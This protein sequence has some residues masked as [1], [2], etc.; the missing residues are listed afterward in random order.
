MAKL[1]VFNVFIPR[2]DASQ[3]TR[4]AQPKF[5]SW[6]VETA[7]RF[8]SVTLVANDVARLW[9]NEQQELQGEDCQ[10]FRVSV[11]PSRR[12]E[13]VGHVARTA[14]SFGQQSLLLE[15]AGEAEIIWATQ[16]DPV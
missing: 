2:T 16:S 5:E 3:A 11:P 6:Y 10:W 1:V 14:A 15:E 13:F 9:M 8:G 7:E 12:A 4:H